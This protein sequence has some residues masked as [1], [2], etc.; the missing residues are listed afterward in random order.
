MLRRWTYSGAPLYSTPEKYLPGASLPPSLDPGS[1]TGHCGRTCRSSW[2]L[3]RPAG[4]GTWF[5]RTW[6]AVRA[7]PRCEAAGCTW[8]V[9]LRG[10][11]PRSWSARCPDPP[12][13]RL[14]TCPPSRHSGGTPGRPSR[15][16]EPSDTPRSLPTPSRSDSPVN[17]SP[18]SDNGTR[19]HSSTKTNQ[20]EVLSGLLEIFFQQSN[21]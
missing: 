20:N 14:W 19:S 8:P 2:S 7:R 9:V 11:V 4:C 16:P 5:R 15:P 18:Y 1:F 6:P 17:E 10:T 21:K 13:G 12:P 3:R